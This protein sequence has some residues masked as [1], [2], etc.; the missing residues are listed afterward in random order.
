MFRKV[1]DVEPSDNINR[2]IY[3]KTVM[4]HLFPLS[5]NREISET[6]RIGKGFFIIFFAFAHI[7]G[8]DC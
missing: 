3:S 5:L 8:M 7:N 2:L 4:V 1:R 6:L